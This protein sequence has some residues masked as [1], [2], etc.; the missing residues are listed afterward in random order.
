MGGRCAGTSTRA[1]YKD[2]RYLSITMAPN[3]LLM[4][5]TTKTLEVI[6]EMEQHNSFAATILINLPTAAAAVVAETI[7][8][9]KPN[10]VLHK[11]VAL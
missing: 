4:L 9:P 1:L 10:D 11:A 8:N 3:G 5:D 6:Q 7:P 2:E